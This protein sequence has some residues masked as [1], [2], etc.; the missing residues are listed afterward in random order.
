MTE[1]Q[2]HV[3]Y[4]TGTRIIHSKMRMECDTMQ[5]SRQVPVFYRNLLLP[6][7]GYKEQWKQHIQYIYQT[8]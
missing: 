4:I 1:S 2:K 5:Y 3:I 6:V 8:T 7:S